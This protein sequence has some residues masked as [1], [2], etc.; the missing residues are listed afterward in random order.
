MKI[1][2]VTYDELPKEMIFT[3][4]KESDKDYVVKIIMQAARTGAKGAYG[5]GKIFVSPVDEST[6]SVRPQRRCGGSRR[7]RRSRCIGIEHRNVFAN[8]P[9]SS[10]ESASVNGPLSPWESTSV[11]GPLSLG[12]G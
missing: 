6:R 8:G 2:E 5:D 3:V 11:N 4:V 9:L 10:W 1:G 7:A 12:E